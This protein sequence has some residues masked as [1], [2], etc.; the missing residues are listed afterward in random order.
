MSQCAAY[1]YSPH[2]QNC[3]MIELDGLEF[4]GNGPAG[5]G[6]GLTGWSGWLEGADATGGPE[7]FS[8][9]DGGYETRVSMQGR[10]IT[11]EGR[12]VASSLGEL[13]QMAD[14]LAR[15][16]AGDRWSEMV[17]TEEALGLVR[18][19]R[20]CRL[21][22]P[23]ITFDEARKTAIFT[24][25]LQSARFEKEAVDLSKVTAALGG[26]ATLTNAGDYAAGMLVTLTGPLT[27]PAVWIGPA[28]LRYTGTIP[29]GVSITID[30]R[31]RVVRD[32]NGYGYRRM[33]SGTWHKL[34]PGSTQV[35]TSGTGTGSVTYEWRSAWM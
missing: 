17:V 29:T 15:V 8:G 27:D 33:V 30:T 12:I 7:P 13:W 16:L 26:A 5:S 10:S 23:Q 28:G 19:L 31:T 34:Q 4:S 14:D 21:R 6:Y 25:E 22:R 3:L 2:A 18:Q 20:V 24:L 11:L 1:P 9:A 32:A 35:F